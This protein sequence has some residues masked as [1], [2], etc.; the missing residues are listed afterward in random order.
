MNSIPEV[1]ENIPRE[2]ITK[3]NLGEDPDAVRCPFRAAQKLHDG[4]DIFYNLGF[5]LRNLGRAGSWVVTRHSLQKEILQNPGVFSSN[6][7][8]SFS[9]LIG[10]NWPLVPLEIDP[11]QHTEYR[12]LMNP[13]FSPREV[14]GLEHGVREAAIELI[15][16]AKKDGECE[17]MEAF[18]RPFP[19]GVFMR[20]M[21]LPLAEMPTFLQWEK[22]ILRG[23]TMEARARAAGSIK[24]YLLEL[25]AKRR[26]NP[27]GDLVSF[28]VTSKVNGEPISDEHVLGICFLLFVGGLDTVAA[29]LG[30]TFK[31][32]ATRPEQQRELRKDP[33]FINSAVEEYLRAFGVVNTSRFLTQDFE[34]H[35][36]KFHKGDRVSITTGLASRDGTAYERPNEIDFSRRD[37][38]NLTL[39]AG[40][41]RCL[42][43]HLARREFMIALQE[44]MKRVPEFRLKEG[45][46]PIAHATGVWGVDYLPLVW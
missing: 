24:E 46:T 10:E 40:P 26:K 20:L 33:A 25:M 29:V 23:D 21:G 42:G 17:F 38:R 19:V 34:F 28:A 13:L 30:F 18:G 15:E 22:D 12:A 16:K 3:W 37:V 5:D 45:E 11:P 41:H 8:A 31:E 35:G 32:L 44:W 4:P 43:S 36:L 39:S 1:R 7:I 9:A 6:R 27:T 14:N 2:L